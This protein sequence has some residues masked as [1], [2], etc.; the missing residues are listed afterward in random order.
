MVKAWLGSLYGVLAKHKRYVTLEL[1]WI[2][3]LVL[4]TAEIK[5]FA[6]LIVLGLAATFSTF[7]KRVFQAP[8]VFELT[9]LTTVAVSV[10]YGPVIGAV[11]TLIV[12]I[13]MEIAAQ[14]LD[15]FSITYIFPR[16]AMAFAAPLLYANGAGFSLPV[17][18]LLAS[19]IYNMLQ[20]PVYWLLTDPEKRIKAL[21]FS[22]L[23]IPLNWLIF[24]FLGGP[25]F[26]ILKAIA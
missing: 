9:T 10:F 20:Q 5:A 22:S 17:L 14:A 15:P 25:L 8:P 23:N 24:K 13:T 3:L 26:E 4:F 16:M 19:G 21:Y 1:I 2:A 7:Y 12:T 6:I 18:G 11:Y